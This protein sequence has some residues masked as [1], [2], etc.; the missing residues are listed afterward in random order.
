MISKNKKNFNLGEKI[1]IA[2]GNG[3]VGS[4]I[5][6][7]L[8]SRGYGNQKNGGVIHS[9]SS[10]K[11]NLLNYQEVDDWSGVIDPGQT[12]RQLQNKVLLSLSKVLGLS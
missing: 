12:D 11:L 8:K 4:S 6:R 3:M 9:P 7:E 5:L 2:G 10:Q 1:F